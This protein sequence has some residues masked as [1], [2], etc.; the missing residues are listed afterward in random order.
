MESN[1]E[2]KPEDDFD[3]WV[4]NTWKIENPIPDK[5]PRY[6][7]FTVLNEKMEK[8]MIH[9]CESN[10]SKILTY[11]YNK[12]LQQDDIENISYIRDKLINLYNITDKRGLIE[13]MISKIE[14]GKY[15]LVH[16]YHSGTCRNP[17]FQIPHFNFNGITLPDKDYY[18][19]NYILA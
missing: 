16:I 4:N 7:N 11:I 14:E 6:T 9:I 15:P 2:Y 5:Y 12:F 18:K 3:N 10:K 1:I 13:Y 17:R 8:L 19:D